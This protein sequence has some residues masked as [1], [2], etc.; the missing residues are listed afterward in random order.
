MFG[1]LEVSNWKSTRVYPLILIIIIASFLR[2]YNLTELP[3]GLYPD[4]AMNG[5][6]AIEAWQ[7]KDWRVFYPENF[8]REGLFINIQSL[9]VAVF[10]NKPWAL[11]LPSAI[12]GILTVLGLYFLTKELFL[13]DGKLPSEQ[14]GL[15]RNEVLAL[16]AMFFLATSFWHI[17]FSRIGFRAIM[18]P[19]FLTWALYFLLL[20]IRTTNRSFIAGH[21]SLVTAVTGGLLYAL[22][23]YSY[24]AYRTTP[25]LLALI[26]WFFAFKANSPLAESFKDERK[27]ILKIGLIFTIT[28]ILA[29]APLGIYFLQ[30]PADFFGR[31]S[32]ISVFASETPFRDLAFNILKT[33]GMFNVVG[34]FNWRHNFAG[35][36]LLFFPAGIFFLIG[37]FIAI[38]N[39]IKNISSKKF[40]FPFFILIFWIIAAALPVVISNEGLPH[41]LRSLLMVPPVFIFAAVGGLKMYEFL[42]KYLSNAVLNSS[43]VIF[44]IILI[45]E[46]YLVYFVAWGKHPSVKNA[47]GYNDYLIAQQFNSLPRETPKYVVVGDARGIIERDNPISLQSF[48][49]LTDTFTDQKR[50]E[51]NLIYLTKDEFRLLQLSTDSEVIFL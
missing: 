51:K 16:L 49:F 34:D 29:A 1:K 40:H 15:K 12:F 31:T 22:G 42:T 23:F 3:P 35:R 47:F 41:A 2:L 28:A 45:F 5:N 43:A 37:L 26:F 30:H 38:R 50:K 33:A 48:L 39:L 14:S 7:N 10:G 18:A 11:R 25:L 9:F 24:I 6:N 19:A 4:E 20:S 44:F 36:P 13:E 21:L 32:G 46:A 8:G 27:N 17:N